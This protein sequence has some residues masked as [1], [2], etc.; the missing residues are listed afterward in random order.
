MIATIYLS[1]Q[2][3]SIVKQLLSTGLYG[4]NLTDVCQRLL[5]EKLRE[6]IVVPKLGLE[7]RA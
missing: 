5:E 3:K 1:A 7:R 4:A 6:F 2:S